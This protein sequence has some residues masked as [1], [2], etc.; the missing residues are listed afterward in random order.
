MGLFGLASFAMA[1]RRKEIGVR[2][3]L[4][5][6]VSGIL[7]LV[8]REFVVMVGI[9]ALLATPIAWSMMAGWLSNF[10]YRTDLGPGVFIVAT[11]VTLVIAQMTVTLHA[12]RAARM[13]P[14]KALRYE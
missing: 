14:V 11:V 5:A 2:K 7:V 12:I 1:E 9:A 10:A 8:S 6:S 3:T 4:G 13:D